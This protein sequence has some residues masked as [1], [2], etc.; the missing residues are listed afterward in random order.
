MLHFISSNHSMS[1]HTI[2]CSSF[3][4]SLDNLLVFVLL[5]NHYNIFIISK[6]YCHIMSIKVFTVLQLALCNIRSLTL[7]LRHLPKIKNVVYVMK[8]HTSE[9]MLIIIGNSYSRSQT[10]AGKAAAI[11]RPFQLSNLSFVPICVS[12]I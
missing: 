6:I 2:T 8:E 9:K 1:A 5:L 10:A 7:S 11:C 12:F 3:N 4:C